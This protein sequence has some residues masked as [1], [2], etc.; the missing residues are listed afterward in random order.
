V[1]KKPKAP[2]EQTVDLTLWMKDG[3]VAVKRGR[4][5]K[6]PDVSVGRTDSKRRV[7][8]MVE[9]PSGREIVRFALDRAQVQSLRDYLDYSLSNRPQ[10]NGTR[11]RYS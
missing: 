2:A 11:V 5:S 9:A 10:G 4:G 8:F 7:G 6:L 3:V 1:A